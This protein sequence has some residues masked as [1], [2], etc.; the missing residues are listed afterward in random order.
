MIVCPVLDLRGE[1][2]LD[3]R[4]QWGKHIN[5]ISKKLAKNLYVLRNLILNISREIL[6]TAYYAIVHSYLA[7]AILVW[8]HSAEIPR[9]FG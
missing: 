6:R 7:Y 9:V 4:P 1:G 3:S 5:N 8:G 2:H